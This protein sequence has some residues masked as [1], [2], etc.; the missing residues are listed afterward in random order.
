MFGICIAMAH[1]AVSQSMVVLCIYDAAGFTMAY[2][3]KLCQRPHYGLHSYGVPG[4]H[5]GLQFYGMP[6]PHYGLQFYGKLGP[7]CGLQINGMPGSHCR[8]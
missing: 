6:G 2:N 7:H 5:Y 4:Q 3:F 1:M 8:V